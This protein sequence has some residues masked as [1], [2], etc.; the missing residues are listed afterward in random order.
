[1]NFDWNPTKNNITLKNLQFEA[2]KKGM[3]IC[4]RKIFNENVQYLK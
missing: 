3:K 1:M 4:G 2:W